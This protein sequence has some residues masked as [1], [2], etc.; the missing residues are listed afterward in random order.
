M[1]ENEIIIK[2]SAKDGGS[3]VPVG[4]A[5][6]FLD[7]MQKILNDIAEAHGIDKK[8]VVLTL[9]NIEVTND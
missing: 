4:E 9:K 7:T 6:K 5:I 3:N 2:I 1:K 8:H